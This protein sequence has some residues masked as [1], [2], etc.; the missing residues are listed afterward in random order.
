MLE[1]VHL[2]ARDDTDANTVFENERDL[3][4]AAFGDAALRLEKQLHN[5]DYLPA[6]EYGAFI[7]P[8]Q[9]GLKPGS[10]YGAA[11]IYPLQQGLK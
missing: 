1:L 4:V 5:Y 10:E 9:Q 3:L 11:I 6:S 2:L 8:I 7:N